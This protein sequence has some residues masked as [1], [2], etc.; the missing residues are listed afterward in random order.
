MTLDAH[1]FLGN[2]TEDPEAYAKR[3]F[4]KNQVLSESQFFTCPE[5]LKGTIFR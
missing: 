2:K 4:E 3:L 5:T 1:Y